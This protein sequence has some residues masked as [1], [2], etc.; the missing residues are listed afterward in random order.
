MENISNLKLD[1]DNLY[2]GFG[3]IHIQFLNHS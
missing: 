3:H 2:D 1:E